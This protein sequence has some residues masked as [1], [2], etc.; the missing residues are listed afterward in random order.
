MASFDSL[1]RVSASKYANARQRTAAIGAV[2]EYIR[3]KHRLAPVYHPQG[4]FTPAWGPAYPRRPTT[5]GHLGVEDSRYSDLRK[6]GT[7][8]RSSSR[9]SQGFAIW[10]LRYGV[11]DLVLC[12]SHVFFFREEQRRAS[13]AI[14]AHRLVW[15][16]AFLVILIQGRYRWVT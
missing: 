6:K 14:L 2:V 4:Q 11:G 15:S 13:R 10:H 9:R 7:N 12:T 5:F 16:S 3:C 8:G 1:W